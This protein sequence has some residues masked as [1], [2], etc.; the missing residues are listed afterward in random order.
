MTIGN[1][2]RINISQKRRLSNYKNPKEEREEDERKKNEDK[3][4][5]AT[6]EL[7]LFQEV[8]SLLI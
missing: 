6:I 5:E 8:V 7:F 2:N 3:L 4:N 1:K